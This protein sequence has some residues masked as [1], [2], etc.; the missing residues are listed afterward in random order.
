MAKIEIGKQ[1][2][3]KV[4]TSAVTLTDNW[5]LSANK[6]A[7]EITSFGD[8]FRKYKV[9]LKGWTATVSGTVD[10]SDAQQA[11]FFDQFEDGTDATF[12]LR[13]Y[14]DDDVGGSNN[15]WYGSAWVISSSVTAA[16]A[17]KITVEWEFQ[18]EDELIYLSS[19][20]S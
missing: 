19:A 7:L 17:D 8:T 5:S 11:G 20:G 15:Y 12:E 2:K 3:V 16:V 4:G 6:D 13:L 10:R 1:A 9:G 18:G 14:A